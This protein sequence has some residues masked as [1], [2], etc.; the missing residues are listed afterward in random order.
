MSLEWDW[1]LFQFQGSAASPKYVNREIT[2]G[3]GRVEI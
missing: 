1:L 3:F 2:A